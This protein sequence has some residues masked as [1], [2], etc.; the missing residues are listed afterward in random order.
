MAHSSRR[1]FQRVDR[2]AQVGMSSAAPITRFFVAAHA[3]IRREDEYL[4]IRRSTQADYGA[5]R[6]ELPGGKVEPGE[7][8]EEALVREI[9]EETGL[10]V[11]VIQLMRA[12]T[13]RDSLPDSQ[14]IEITYLCTHR[15]GAIQLNP[16]EHDLHRWLS[17]NDLKKLDYPARDFLVDLLSTLDTGTITSSLKGAVDS[18]IKVTRHYQIL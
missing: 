13:N 4:I 7:T 14:H 17:L 8:V 5:R 3:L 12:Y 1:E 6:W 10:T 16:R 15:S 9:F 18:I 2:M 11:D